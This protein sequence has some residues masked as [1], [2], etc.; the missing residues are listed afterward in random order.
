MDRVG[1][2]G[3]HGLT[4]GNETFTQQVMRL[5]PTLISM[6][7]SVSLLVRV[8]E[9]MVRNCMRVFSALVN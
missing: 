4:A 6:T 3:C 8:L 2:R 1:H 7:V 9:I 5:S